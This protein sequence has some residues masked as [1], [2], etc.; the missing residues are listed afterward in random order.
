[1]ALI[2]LETACGGIVSVARN[3]H[4]RGGTVWLGAYGD[5]EDRAA[6]PLTM[7]E[8]RFVADRLLEAANALESRGCES[9]VQT[10]VVVSESPLPECDGSCE[11]CGKPY[12]PESET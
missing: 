3:D 5:L 2:L 11:G 6:I 7:F 8:A 1:M 10:T 12:E 4:F 9:A